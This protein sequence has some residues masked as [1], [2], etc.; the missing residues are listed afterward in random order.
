MSSYIGRYKNL[1]PNIK[2]FL[3]VVNHECGFA[4]AAGLCNHLIVRQHDGTDDGFWDN[5]DDLKPYERGKLIEVAKAHG[6]T[7]LGAYDL[8]TPA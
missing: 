3:A 6:Y 5:P 8:M 4:V 7:K 1:A 2:M